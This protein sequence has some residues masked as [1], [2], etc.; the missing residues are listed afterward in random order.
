[1]LV[2]GPYILTHYVISVSLIK[3]EY[4]TC[5]WKLMLSLIEVGSPK[6]KSGGKNVIRNLLT[7]TLKSVMYVHYF[8]LVVQDRPKVALTSYNL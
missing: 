2:T 1:M 4:T 7:E 3:I 6:A 8:G 5:V